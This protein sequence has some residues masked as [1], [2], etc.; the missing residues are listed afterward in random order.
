[1]E[2]LGDHVERRRSGGQQLAH[3][4][5]HRFHDPLAQRRDAAQVV[6]DHPVGDIV[7]VEGT[8]QVRGAHGETT[9]TF[10]EVRPAAEVLQVEGFGCEWVVG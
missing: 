7:A 6:D 2:L 9:N 1:M 4:G 3:D 10:G 5:A 8:A